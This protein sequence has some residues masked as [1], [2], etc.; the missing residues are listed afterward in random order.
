MC[1]KNIQSRTI[2]G[3]LVASWRRAGGRITADYEAA[4][5]LSVFCLHSTDPYFPLASLQRYAPQNQWH[6]HLPF[7]LL[8]IFHLFLTSDVAMTC[9]GVGPTP[10]GVKARIFL[11]STLACSL[12]VTKHRATAPYLFSFI[13]WSPPMLAIKPCWE[14]LLFAM[15]CS[16]ASCSCF[17]WGFLVSFSLLFPPTTSFRLIPV[18]IDLTPWQYVHIA[19]AAGF[20]SA[21]QVFLVFSLLR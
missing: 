9:H 4:T 12:Q 21:L 16:P 10:A 20:T 18:L 19:S 5:S 13:S 11:F 15:P 17:S 6:P 2:L 8:P 1:E 14:I 3:R 7:H